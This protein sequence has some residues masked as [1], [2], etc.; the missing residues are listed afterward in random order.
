M[1]RHTIAHCTGHWLLSVS[2]TFQCLYWM[3]DCISN[4][5]I[6]HSPHA[7]MQ[8]CCCHCSII[9]Y[10]C[11]APIFNDVVPRSVL[12]FLNSSPEKHLSSYISWYHFHY[13]TVFSQKGINNMLLHHLKEHFLMNE[14][15][16]CCW[17]A[18]IVMKIVMFSFFFQHKHCRENG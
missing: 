16:R 2:V 15:R 4:H 9:S 17:R 10:F 12:Q 18:L 3:F 8:D 5:K 11:L 1:H 14:L 6:T 13:I 7:V